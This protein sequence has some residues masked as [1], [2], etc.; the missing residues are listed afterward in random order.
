V[1]TPSGNKK[2]AKAASAG[3]G[4]SVRRGSQSKSFNATVI[5]VCVA[6]I[7]LVVG[8]I[9]GRTIAETAPYARSISKK[10]ARAKSAVDKLSDAKTDSERKALAAAQKE[11]EELVSDSHVHAAYGV[12]N[13]DKYLPA[14]NGQ[15]LPDPLG[16]HAH[17]DGLI[18]IHPFGSKSAGRNARMGKWFESTKMTMTTKKISWIADTLGDKKNTLDVNKDTC[19]PKKQ[20]AEIS[21]W[22][23]ADEKAKPQVITDDF[24]SVKLTKNAIYAFVFAPKGTKVPIPATAKTIATPSDA[25]TEPEL[26]PTSPN[27]T[28]TIPAAT[29]TTKAGTATT[30]AGTAT[31]VK[32]D[33]TATT[34]KADATAT[35]VKADATA[36]TVKADEAATTTTKAG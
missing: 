17:E 8:S 3:G 24:G 5:G 29:A 10:V 23:W 12:F 16:I 28:T 19:G 22:Y 14:F 34:V 20:K 31:T 13:C 18:H 36:T 9:I 4:V 21:M 32:A 27:G 26:D 1:G 25:N 7:A 35:T 33:A 6:G 11:Y 30:K 15:S 2:V